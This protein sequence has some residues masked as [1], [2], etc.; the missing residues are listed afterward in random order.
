MPLT[1]RWGDWPPGHPQYQGSKSASSSVAAHGEHV[2]S[3]R[4]YSVGPVLICRGWEG[5]LGVAFSVLGH[6]SA[7]IDGS[8]DD[9][10]IS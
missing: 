5:G 6:L 7:S 2:M 4:A 3:W 8:P 1:R 9:D 10:T